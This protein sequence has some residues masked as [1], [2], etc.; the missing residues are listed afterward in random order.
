[1]TNIDIHNNN[2]DSKLVLDSR[3]A[4]N[5]VLLLK[6]QCHFSISYIRPY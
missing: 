6:D 5:N 3:Y 4:Q 2:A 1:M